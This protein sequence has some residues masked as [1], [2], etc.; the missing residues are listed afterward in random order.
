MR[1]VNLLPSAKEDKQR[2][3]SFR[4]YATIVGV[5]VIGVAVALPIILFISK[6]TQNLVL[7][8]VQSQINE[9]QKTIENTPDIVTMLTVK[10]HLDALPDLYKQ[11]NYMT[12]LYAILPSIVNTDIKLKSLDA[13]AEGNI[14][15]DG[16]S[17]SYAAVNKFFVALS[18][19][20]AKVD[21]NAINK[22]TDGVFSDLVLENASGTSGGQ[23][24]FTIKGKYSKSLTE[25]VN[26]GQ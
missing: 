19:Y 5:V 24:D 17:N 10:D 23:I 21:P 11:R 3:D 22:I 8:R 20:G 1:D 7:S 25:K 15:F 12:N 6:T 4:H 13:D 18:A 2:T 14:Q 26:N 16:T 9:R